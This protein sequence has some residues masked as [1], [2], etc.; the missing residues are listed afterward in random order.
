VAKEQQANLENSCNTK[1]ETEFQIGADHAAQ[2]KA[3]TVIHPGLKPLG[4]FAMSFT[5]KPAFQKIGDIS[6]MP[7]H[8][9]RSPSYS[10]TAS[11][12]PASTAFLRLITLSPILPLFHVDE[13]LSQL[14]VIAVSQPRC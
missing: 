3:D 14:R 7:R 10:F 11:C 4:S 8:K 13:Y 1:P 2:Q 12:A 5:L 9:Q 6:G